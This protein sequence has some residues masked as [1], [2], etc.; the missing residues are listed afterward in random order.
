MNAERLQALTR[1][2]ARRFPEMRQ[3]RPR[4]RRLRLPDGSPGY[5][6]VYRTVVRAADGR[7]LPRSV[8]VLLNAKGQILKITTSR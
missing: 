3:V 1:R 5:L 2:I 8:R 7:A 6:V 4:W